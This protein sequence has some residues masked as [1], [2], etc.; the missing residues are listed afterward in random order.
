MIP[1]TFLRMESLVLLANLIP[2]KARKDSPMF[3]AVLIRVGR[4]LVPT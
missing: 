2:H 1:E 4:A 3:F